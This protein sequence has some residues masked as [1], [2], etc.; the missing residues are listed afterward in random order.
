MEK[1]T[2]QEFMNM[3]FRDKLKKQKQKE[4]EY[5]GFI[6]EST[7]RCAKKAHSRVKGQR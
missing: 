7:R 5:Y 2:K 4:N 1:L 6:I 3:Y